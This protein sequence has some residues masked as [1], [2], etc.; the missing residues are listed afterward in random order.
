MVGLPPSAGWSI[1]VDGLDGDSV[2][3]WFLTFLLFSY[4]HGQ[5]ESCGHV[6]SCVLW[7]AAVDKDWTRAKEEKQRRQKGREKEAD[8]RK[9]KISEEEAGGRNG[10]CAQ[11][12]HNTGTGLTELVYGDKT[13]GAIVRRC[14]NGRFEKVMEIGINTADSGKC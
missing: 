14:W 4:L 1:G 9:S 2:L 5:E 3:E 11:K 6:H 12:C 7:P 13:V 10:G 8:Q